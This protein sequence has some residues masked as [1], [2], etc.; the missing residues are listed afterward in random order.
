MTFD[1][2]PGDFCGVVRV[3]YTSWSSGAPEVTREIVSVGRR[4]SAS[5][6]CG[7][8]GYYSEYELEV[9]ADFTE[10]V[11][12]VCSAHTGDTPHGS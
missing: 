1:D 9:L 11:R 6:S 8:C 4:N 3:V 12:V 5:G 7:C 2:L 10:R